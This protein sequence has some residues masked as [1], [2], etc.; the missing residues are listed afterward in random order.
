MLKEIDLSWFSI[1]WFLPKTLWGFV[2]DNQF[3]LYLLPG[4]P[5]FFFLRW[6]FYVRFRQKLDF[7]FPDTRVYRDWLTYLRFIPSW[8]LYLSMSMVILALGRPQRQNEGVEQYTEGIDIVLALDVSESMTL[9]DLQPDRLEAAKEVANEFIHGRTGDR[10][11]LVVFSGEAYSLCPLT[12]DYS[13]LSESIGEIHHQMIEKTGTAIGSALAVSTN[14]LRE[15]KGK[16]RVIVLL[17][18]GENNAGEI[19]PLMAARLAQVYQCKIYT[20][21]VGKNG[22][23]PYINEAGKKEMVENVLD[24]TTLR[25]I[26]AIGKGA[27]FRATDN[28]SL[29]QVFQKINILEKTKIKENRFKNA[30]D[31]Y[32]VY[33][34]WGVVFFLI[35]LLLKSSFMSNVLED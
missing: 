23:V 19:E 3:A 2:W 28:K 27:F 9:L 7:A 20:I 31:Y 6:A 26:A 14:R 4:I 34:I 10:I 1:D 5:L 25:Q 17:S 21:A 8:F 33:L 22:N 30:R 32:Q 24:E 12:T 15:S 11:G 35:W 18:D 29:E 16:S 13:L